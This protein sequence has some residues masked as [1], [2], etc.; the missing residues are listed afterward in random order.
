MDSMKTLGELSM[1]SRLKRLS[2][3]CM[4][5]IQQVYDSYSIDFDPYLFPA[6]SQISKSGVTTNSELRE[7][8]QISQPAVTQYINKLQ[9]KGLIELNGNPDDKRSKQI[10]LSSK[11][12]RLLSRMQPL[13]NSMDEAVKFFTEQ[14]ADSLISHINTF[15]EANRS[16]A[17]LSRIMD[18]V[19]KQGHLPISHFQPKFAQ[20]F[21]DYNIE[22]LET[23]FYVEDYDREV[24]SN[25]RKYI[26][27]PGGHIFF[28][29][30][31]DTAVGTVALMPYEE[32]VFELTKMAVP[33]EHRGKK[34]GQQLMQ[35][36]I[37]FA[38]DQDYDKLILYS[39]TILEN[40]I[41]IYRKYGFIE[42]PQ[43]PDVPYE[44]SNIKM[45]LKL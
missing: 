31:N 36:C 4:R 37:D 24:L 17:F 14:P 40:A 16:G 11:G 30:E 28:A 26:L 33:P 41:Y 20:A 13:W 8:L 12:E 19:R 5:N 22:W 15:E 6:Y 35:Y 21:Y 7:Y 3:L 38:K 1:G 2:E 25:P 34:I 44:R 18:S 10:R 42:I 32:G 39:N 29:L 27:D 9:K 43:E 45:E 23:F